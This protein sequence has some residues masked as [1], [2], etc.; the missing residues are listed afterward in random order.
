MKYDLP[1]FVDHLNHLEVILVECG[2]FVVFVVKL[3][4]FVKW[5]IGRQ[6]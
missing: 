5:M 2:L 1:E 4:R 3:Y 6:D